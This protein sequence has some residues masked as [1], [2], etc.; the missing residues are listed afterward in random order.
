V[1]LKGIA[2]Q[3]KQAT[4]TFAHQNVTDGASNANQSSSGLQITK[5]WTPMVH[6]LALELWGLQ[7]S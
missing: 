6:S 1:L 7:A 3:I 4:H 5:C 2:Q